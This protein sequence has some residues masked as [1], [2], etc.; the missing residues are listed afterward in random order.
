MSE[1]KAPVGVVVDSAADVPAELAAR[2]NMTV[3]PAF[4][5][6]GPESYPDDGIAMP[7]SEFYR[8]LAE[9]KVMPTTSAMPPGLAVEMY[10]KALERAERLLVFAVAGN[11]SSIYNTLVLAAEQVA[12]ERI[13]VIDTRS[14]SMGAGYQALAAAEALGRGATL[15]E[16]IAAAEAVRPRIEIWAAA[17]TLEYLRRGGR[18]STVVAGIGALLQIK[19]IIAL[20]DGVVSI[21]QRARTMS[22]AVDTIREW[23]RACAP[24]ERLTILHADYRDG[25]AALLES[26][27]DVAP[28]ETW[29]ADVNTGIGVHIGPGALGAILVRGA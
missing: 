12:P 17:A 10:H 4:I 6:F 23:V 26:L 1:R 2:W 25:A 29:F 16:A 20:K 3:I 13:T 18:V 5:N 8:Q 9:A 14:A 22:R 24:L 19:P 15:D 28:A 21:P 7:R 27:R 11:L